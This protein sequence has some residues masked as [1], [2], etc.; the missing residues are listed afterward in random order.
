[1]QYFYSLVNVGCL[2]KDSTITSEDIKTIYLIAKAIE[3][4]EIGN[5]D[6]TC[7]LELHR[8]Q[9]LNMLKDMRNGKRDF[10]KGYEL[11]P[12][13][14]LGREVRLGT[15]IIYSNEVSLARI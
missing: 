9:A 6:F 14:V 2:P 13:K 5:V 15:G 4:G 10:S 8:V 7:E 3:S 12:Y 1:M 11:P